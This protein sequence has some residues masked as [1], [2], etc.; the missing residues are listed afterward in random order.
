[1]TFFVC[2]L[3]GS[4][5]SSATIAKNAMNVSELNVVAAGPPR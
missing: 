1:L 5:C 3:N 4:L 2:Q